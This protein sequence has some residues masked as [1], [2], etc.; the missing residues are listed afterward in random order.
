MEVE[1]NRIDG[2]IIYDRNIPA[3]AFNLDFNDR[4]VGIRGLIPDS[5]NVLTSSPDSVY[6]AKPTK[7]SSTTSSITP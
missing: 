6:H 3:S 5:R 1:V 2:R 4:L 7:R